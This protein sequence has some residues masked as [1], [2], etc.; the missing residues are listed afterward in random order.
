MKIIEALKQT[1]DLARKADDLIGKIKLYCADLDYENPVYPDQKGQIS[2]WIQAHRDICHEV[3]RLKFCIQ[4]TNIMTQV[5]IQIGDCAITKSIAEWIIRRKELACIE[6]MAWDA[7]SDRQLKDM[8]IQTT[9]QEVKDVK[10][11][12]YFDASERDKWRAELDS[13]PSLID[14]KLEIVNAITDLIE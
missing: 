12:R 7:L 13:E 9:N 1:K 2:K 3:L 6:K 8:R 4:K 14:A 11:R 5:T 10:V